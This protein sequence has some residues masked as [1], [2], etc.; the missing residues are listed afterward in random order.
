[1]IRVADESST[2]PSLLADLTPLLDIIFIVLVFLMLSANTP[3]L[4]LP[5]ELP[6]EGAERAEAVKQ[7]ETITVSLGKDGTDWGLEGKPYPS[8]QA[9]QS[10]LLAVHKESPDRQVVIAGDRQAPIG[11]L[12][13]LLSFLQ[14]VQWP[15][16]SILMEQK[17][18]ND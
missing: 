16:A 11:H 18:V 10:A 12:V 1:M 4:A 17:P 13:Q 6:T 15:A 2:Q 9:L 14:S 5:V 8:W 7:P 3:P